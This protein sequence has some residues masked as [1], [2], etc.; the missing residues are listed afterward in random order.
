MGIEKHEVIKIEPTND[1]VTNE[2]LKKIDDINQK[3]GY[4]STKAPIRST[5]N[6]E[7][8]HFYQHSFDRPLPIRLGNFLV[9]KFRGK[10]ISDESDKINVE[11]H[12]FIQSQMLNNVKGIIL[13]S[14]LPPYIQGLSNFNPLVQNLP[15][16]NS[17]IPYKKSENYDSSGYINN[18]PNMPFN[19]YKVDGYQ[20]DRDIPKNTKPTENG[21]IGI[22][23]YLR[24]LFRL[25]KKNLTEI[26]NNSER[27]GKE[28]YFLPPQPGNKPTFIIESIKKGVQIAEYN[29]NKF[30]PFN[31]SPRNLNTTENQSDNDELKLENVAKVFINNST[32]TQN[33][34]EG[35]AVTK[36]KKSSYK[37]L[38]KNDNNTKTLNPLQLLIQTQ[39][40]F[41]QTT[42]QPPPLSEDLK[43]VINENNKKVLSRDN[44]GSGIFIHRIKVKKGGVAIAGPGGIATAGSGGTAIVGP[45]GYAY[46]HP[47]SL[48]IAGTGSKVIAVEPNVSLADI[49]NGNHKGRR[50]GKVV[51]IGPV[52]YYNKG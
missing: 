16:L 9:E 11:K 3:Y 20:P 23:N 14:Q 22:F 34:R 49:I 15:F 4:T 51:A 27:T 29:E 28:Y 44:T 35:K 48:A 6:V 31:K 17:F 10:S 5:K 50:V 26:S 41:K 24:I 47:D 19:E 33:I 40:K 13:K 1:T 43:D 21:N 18:V 39:N 52:I 30:H 46:T 42:T 7:I 32:L 12:N 45:N 25:D 8:P 37:N 36:N 2:I 38:Q